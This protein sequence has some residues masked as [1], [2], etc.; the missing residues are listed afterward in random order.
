MSF[1]GRQV[2]ELRVGYADNKDKYWYACLSYFE[3]TKKYLSKPSSGLQ[4]LQTNFLINLLLEV[5]PINPVVGKA[6]LHPTGSNLPWKEI[7]NACQIQYDHELS[8]VFW[9]LCIW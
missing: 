3:K 5:P 4:G 8:E 1:N 7:F 6:V 2:S 9:K